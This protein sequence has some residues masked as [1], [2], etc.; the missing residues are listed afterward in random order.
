M[1]SPT[2]STPADEPAPG[3]GHLLQCTLRLLW[4]C[5]RVPALLLLV[6][7]EPVV[8]FESR[9]CGRLRGAYGRP[10]EGCSMSD[11]IAPPRWP[12]VVHH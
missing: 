7:L 5:I 6:V 12:A 11:I 10:R 4:Q 3:A 1:S 8:S 2:F 9:V